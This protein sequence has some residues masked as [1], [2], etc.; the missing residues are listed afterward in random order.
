MPLSGAGRY[1]ET[2]TYTLCGL[3]DGGGLVASAP[4]AVALGF[5]DGVHLGHAE[6]IKAAVRQG[7]QTVV[8]TFSHNPGKVVNGHPVP[9][10]T[11][12]PLKEKILE[13]MG[14]DG[15]VYLEFDKVRDMEPRR[16]IEMLRAIFSVKYISAGFNYRFGKGAAAGVRELEEICAPLG[17]AVCPVAPVSAEGQTLSSTRIRALIESGEVSGA[18]RLLGRPFAFYGEIVHGRRLGRTLGMPTINQ[19]LPPPQLLPR[20]GVYASVVNISGKEWT[21]VTNVGVKPTI[22]DNNEPLAETYIPGFEGDLYGR[23]LQVDLMD[24]LRP[25]IH[26]AGLDELKEQMKKDTEKAQKLL[27]NK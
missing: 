11:C 3:R 2:E 19:L 4:T 5:F 6:V 26:F 21:A 22:S 13:S 9:E 12:R 10:I 23:I 15:I 25:E 24:F 1:F 16:F 20:F 7:I 27:M 14:A 17:I 8:V 18:A